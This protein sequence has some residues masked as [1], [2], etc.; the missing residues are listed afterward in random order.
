MKEVSQ[1]REGIGFRVLFPLKE[2]LIHSRID[3]GEK[4]GRTSS[5]I[6]AFSS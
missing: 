1:V 5:E 2:K 6:Y 4:L 3:S